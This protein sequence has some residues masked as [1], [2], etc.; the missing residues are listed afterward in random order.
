[1]WT[2]GGDKV[3]YAPDK[4]ERAR[5]WDKRDRFFSCLEKHYIDNSLDPKELKR[6]DRDCGTQK[7]EFEHDCATSWVK[8]FQEKRYNDLVRQRYI[9]K[10]ESEGAQPLPFK[11]EGVKK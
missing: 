9:D 7:K 8:Y 11:I 2:P 1:M 10:L 6:V 4:G 5:C 3:T